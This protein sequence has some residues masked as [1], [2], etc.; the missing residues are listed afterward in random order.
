[1]PPA[2]APLAKLG[3]GHGRN[4]ESSA[5]TARFERESATPNETIAI[6]YDRREN[7]IAMGVLPPPLDRALEPNPFPGVDRASCRIRRRVDANERAAASIARGRGPSRILA[8]DARAR[9]RRCRRT[10]RDEDL[11]LA[12]A[13]GDAAAFDTLY[14]RHKGGVYR[15]LLRQCG[16][17]GIADELFQDVWMNVI[18]VRATLRADARSSRRGSTGS[19]TTG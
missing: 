17:A 3:T 7:L 9:A 14:A 13:A 2:P 16:N 8:G 6:H 19:R 10:T 1:M 11:M 15:Y 12:Y 18:R 5:Q 4:E